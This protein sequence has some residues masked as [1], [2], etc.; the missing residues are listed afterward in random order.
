MA[1]QIARL[2]GGELTVVSS[3]GAGQ[4]ISAAC[5]E[6]R[7]RRRLEGTLQRTDASG[8]SFEGA[9][10]DGASAKRQAA[11]SEESAHGKY[12]YKK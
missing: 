2:H 11:H 9:L 6:K 3:L 4:A 10:F 5:G 1:R 12:F 7:E 8:C